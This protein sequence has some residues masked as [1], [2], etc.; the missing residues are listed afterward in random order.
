MAIQD[1]PFD[2]CSLSEQWPMGTK[3]CGCHKNLEFH[4]RSWT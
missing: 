4:F 3:G 2:R 1:F